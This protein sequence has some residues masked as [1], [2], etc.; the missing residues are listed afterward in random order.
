MK[1]LHTSDWHI[2][3]ATIDEA[4]K[5]LDWLVATAETEKPN[6]I[7]HAGDV[8]NNGDVKLDSKAAKIVTK[9]INRLAEIAPVA[10]VLGT[11]SHDG[12]AAETLSYTKGQHDVFVALVPEQMYLYQGCFYRTLIGSLQPEAVLT[13]IPQPTKQFFKSDS[14]I[15]T[16]DQ[17][18]GAAMSAVFAG[19]GAKAAAFPVA[20]HILVGHWAT[21]G[22]YLSEVQ[23]LTGIDI[24]ISTDQMMLARPNLVC[25]GHLHL[26]QKYYCGSLFSQNWGETSVKGV[27]IH[28]IDGGE[29]ISRF[30]PSP[31]RRMAR[32]AYDLRDQEPSDFIYLE[33]EFPRAEGAHLRIDLTAWQDEA[34]EIDKKLIAEHYQDLGALD[35]DIR[36]TR[37]PRENV[38]A[39]AVLAAETLRDKLVAM[40]ALRNETV[41]ESVLVKADALAG[42]EPDALLAQV[43]KGVAA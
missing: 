16:S 13:L 27:N 43:Q 33:Q 38:R 19:F 34:G 10:V 30:L 17:E 42:M 20:P 2:Q 24:E 6:V 7:I 41:T 29:V 36:I 37:M 9:T 32:L 23:V 25:L 12:R 18:I 1:I 39:N 28:E 4:V 8:F 15:A 40:A 11:P 26:M 3:D 35:V 21:S 5:C 22:A 31:S 14:N